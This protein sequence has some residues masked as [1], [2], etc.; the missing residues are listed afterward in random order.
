MVKKEAKREKREVIV[1][2]TFHWSFTVI[3]HIRKKLSPYDSG[4]QVGDS[5]KRPNERMK[6]S[7]ESITEENWQTEQ[8]QVPQQDEGESCGYRMLSDLNKV[9][10]GQLI[11]H[12]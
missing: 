10:K 5:H 12:E 7:L 11:Q 9:I 6:T 8:V 2:L 3:D 1:H 4:I